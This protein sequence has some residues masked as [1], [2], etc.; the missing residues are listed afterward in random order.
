MSKEYVSN[1]DKY[2]VV[3]VSNARCDVGWNEIALRLRKEIR[4]GRFVIAVECYSGCNVSEIE[5]SLSSALHPQAI[6]CVENCYLSEDAITALTARDLGDDPVFG[7]MNNYELSEFLD[8]GKLCQKRREL[9]S[10]TGLV[11]VVGTG[12]TLLAEQW[13]LLVYC[14]LARW[15]I[16]QRQRSGKIGNLGLDNLD[17]RP[18]IKYKRAYFVDWRAADRHKKRLFSRIDF[19]LDTNQPDEP[20]MIT[21]SQ[22]AEGLKRAATRPFRVVPFFDPGP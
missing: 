5:S 3:P 21:G 18:S 15:E 12:A 2:P 17:E 10:A 20:K 22:F 11:F 6:L 16:Q 7:F 19:L 13:D 9:K 1:Y 4:P 8:E 14:D